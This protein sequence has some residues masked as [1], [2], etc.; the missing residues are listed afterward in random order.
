MSEVLGFIEIDRQHLELLP[1]R[2]VMSMFMTDAGTAGSSGA[3]GG[4]AATDSGGTGSADP[5][6][7]DPMQLVKKIPFVGA[8]LVKP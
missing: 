4:T 1:A 7:L 8:L 2:T 5:N 6:Q 3:T